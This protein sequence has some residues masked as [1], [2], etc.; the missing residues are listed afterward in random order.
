MAGFAE[1]DPKVEQLAAESDVSGFAFE[2]KWK[3]LQ[4]V[5]NFDAQL[6]HFLYFFHRRLY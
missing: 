2:R 4:S 3:D 6:F 5:Y 1:E